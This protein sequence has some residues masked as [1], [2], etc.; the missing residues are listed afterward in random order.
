[1]IKKTRSPVL[2]K[3]LC[4]KLIVLTWYF[5]LV[6]QIWKTE[7]DH[8]VSSFHVVHQMNVYGMGQILVAT[9]LLF[10]ILVVKLPSITEADGQEHQQLHR[11]L[12]FPCS[13]NSTSLYFQ[14]SSRTTL[15]QKG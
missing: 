8:Q 10:G 6:A 1:M 11:L 14:N 5:I 2:L 9:Y 3:E 12:D 13:S 7:V 15:T 4:K